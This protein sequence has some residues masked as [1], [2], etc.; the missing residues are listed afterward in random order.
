MEYAIENIYISQMRY[1]NSMRI[2]LYMLRTY[3]FSHTG[4]QFKQEVENK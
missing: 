2:S 3:A 1:P 4:L